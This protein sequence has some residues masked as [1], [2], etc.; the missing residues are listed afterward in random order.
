MSEDKT[1]NLGG[2]KSFEERVF[3]RF[4]AIDERFDRVDT[5]L[6]HMDARIASVENRLE[7]LESK[8]F[9]TKPIWEKAL[10]AITE[11]NKRIDKLG[12]EFDFALRDVGRKI[13]VLN[14]NIL[15][16]RADYRY[17]EG[18]L[19]KIETGLKQ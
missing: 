17:F 4:D 13:D 18:R 2:S 19:A 6:D 16:V 9:D 7:V 15:E 12:V 10:D 11:T 5:R 8:Q 14:Q 3:A 1:L